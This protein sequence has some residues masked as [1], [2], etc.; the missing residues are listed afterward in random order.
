M[1]SCV[2]RPG[3]VDAGRRTRPR[4]AL[5][6]ALL[7]AGAL[8][9]TSCANPVPPSGGPP[10]QTP[11][12]IV[13]MNPP[14]GAVNVRDP[15]ISVTFSEYVDQASFARAFSISPSP[16]GRIEYRWRRRSVEILLPE[17]LR[18]HTTYVLTIDNNL[19]DL[20]GVA[21]RQPI[22]L[23]FSTGPEIDRAT[24]A[25]R[26]VDPRSGAG[27]GGMDVF[28]YAAPDSTWPD[29]LP[30]RPDYRTQ[31]DASGAFRF[32]YLNPRPY[33]V[34]ALQDRNR[35]RRPDPL[36]PF[37]VPPTPVILADTASATHQETWYATVLDTLPPEVQRIR[38]MSSRR[39]EVRFNEPIRIASVGPGAWMLRDSVAQQVVP[40]R[41][42]YAN[43][44][45]PQH[46][47]LL[48][49]SLAPTPHALLTAAVV[50]TAGNPPRLTGARFIPIA[51]ADT[52]RTRFV[53]FLPDTAA[54][55]GVVGLVPWQQVEIRFNQPLDAE[56]LPAIVSVADSAGTPI[57]FS[58]HTDDGTG[59]RLGFEDTPSDG[60]RFVVS[61]DGSR[62]N[63]I[64]TT[65]VRTFRVLP[66]RE[67]GSL[68]GAVVASH[69]EH[70][71]V[72][73]I[74]ANGTTEEPYRQVVADSSG[75]FLVP[76]LPPGPYRIRAFVD[77]DGDGRWD[78]GRISPYRPAEPV[79]WSEDAVRVR[80][81]WD[82]ALEQPLAIGTRPDDPE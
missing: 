44:D 82:T 57:P 47:Y 60:F 39:V 23:A 5:R 34:L 9:A 46:V 11:P 52:V 10:D 55:D 69:L 43:P 17:A 54:A 72:V 41:A 12:S 38:P 33:A 81:R 76:L 78:G 45:A 6:A 64:D 16:D 53:G 75:R 65:Y 58:T 21:L 67:L 56:R 70:D 80:A 66:E 19:R 63:G 62:L 51:A 74:Y 30:E 50:D 40:L 36:E 71:V 42:V 73:E 77:L 29:P 1:T 26:V 31:T 8:L 49:D 7:A 24:L 68:S 4:T 79:A 61:V 15:G 3:H 22:T 2:R 13:E 37:A 59:Y 25:G 27:V 20:N 35:N 32:E 48:T 28:A 18:E 14:D